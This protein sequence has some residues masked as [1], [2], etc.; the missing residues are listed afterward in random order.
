MTIELRHSLRIIQVLSLFASL[1]ASNCYAGSDQWAV[2]VGVD[3]YVQATDLRYCGA[4]VRALR[5]QLVDVGFPEEQIKLLHD[6]AEE[7]RF[8]PFRGNIDKQ[9]E[10]V[11]GLAGPGDTVVIAFSGHGVH[12]SGKSYFCPAE[13]E[14]DDPSTLV[15]LDELYEQLK[16]CRA[17]VKL[18][19]VDAC[20]NNPRVPGA[21][22]LSEDAASF[23]K[24]LQ[25]LAAT[26][27]PQRRTGM[28]LL[29]SC[30]PGEKSYEEPDFAH[31]VFMHFVLQGLAGNA[32]N[33]DDGRVSFQELADFVG[34]STRTYVA[35][36]FNA[37]QRPFLRSD[38][39]VEQ[40]QEGF[41][42][43]LILVDWPRFRGPDGRGR[44]DKSK[45]VT[46]W[47]DET[48]LRW[49]AQLPGK[50]ASSP[51]V[52]G[53]RVFL[54]C[55]SGYP[56]DDESD[57]GKDSLRRHLLCFDRLTGRKHWEVTKG[58]EYA[59]LPRSE[60][61]GV[62]GYASSTPVSDGNLVYTFWGRAG[63]FAWDMDGNQVWH[64]DVVEGKPHDAVFGSASSPVLVGDVVVVSASQ[65]SRSILGLSK[66]SGSTIW[67][68]KL[69]ETQSDGVFSTPLTIERSQ[70]KEVV[71]QITDA[72]WGMDPQTGRINWSASR[73]QGKE[74]ILVPAIVADTESVY[75]FCRRG[76]MSI[77]LGRRGF[78]SETALHWTSRA[79]ALRTTPLLLNSVFCIAEDTGRFTLVDA[80][81][82]VVRFESRDTFKGKVLASPVADRNHIFIQTRTDGTFVLDRHSFEFVANNHFE[83]DESE[84]VGT[85]AI[86]GDLIY[87]R[88]DEFLY[89]VG[90]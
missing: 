37:S 83:E 86:S 5:Q 38:V 57:D 11:L 73:S 69:T 32:D 33:D 56:N 3:D 43:P 65:E 71:V 85:P 39:A 1:L 62:G 20:R 6:D 88:S 26:P 14:L 84:F 2:L 47:D 64:A 10:L 72:V 46:K 60:L 18:I 52:V 82:G 55:Y 81:T 59:P 49:K 78:L 12:I 40:L 35:D 19:M 61:S 31:G 22:D 90:P 54:T 42:L 29:S 15:S 25:V 7:N 45:L 67:K 87:I 28:L 58:S 30:A 79:R 50:G 75:A 16:Q 70:G 53:D 77:P 51:I 63:V 21:K 36:R 89:C 8:R 74:N 66:L 41:D 48:N 76:S 34:R 68:K 23:T 24:A 13:A 27:N 17:A 4:D 44:A 9:L 80:N